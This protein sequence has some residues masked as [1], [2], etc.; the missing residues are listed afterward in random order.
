MGFPHKSAVFV[1]RDRAEAVQAREDGGGTEKGRAG[2]G[3]WVAGKESR[4]AG[5]RESEWRESKR[6]KKKKKG[7]G[8]E[9]G[10]LVGDSPFFFSLLPLTLPSRAWKGRGRGREGGAGRGWAG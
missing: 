4:R 7:G 10:V 5:G 8:G 3:G 2:Q 6:K 9:P 1:G